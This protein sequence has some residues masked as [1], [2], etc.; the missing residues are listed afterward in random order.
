M[1]HRACLPFLGFT[2]IFKEKKSMRN[3]LIAFVILAC[4]SGVTFAS[5]LF[6]VSVD[7]A[8]DVFYK[9]SFTG[10]Y[11]NEK[12]EIPGSPYKYQG[13]GDTK[14][15]QSS[16]FDNSIEGRVRFM[17]PGTRLGGLLELRTN[18]D[19]LTADIWY[20]ETWL[21]LGPVRILAGNQGQRGQ[22]NQYQNFDDFLSTKID[23]CG[24]LIPTWQKNWYYTAGNNFDAIESFPWGYSDPEENKGFA[25]FASSDTNDLF[26]PAG[27][28]TRLPL[29]ILFDLTIAPVTITASFGGLFSEYTRPFLRPWSVGN[30]E[31]LIDW[32]NAYD[33]VLSRKVNFGVRVETVDIANVI[34]FAATYK[35]SDSLL[36]KPTAKIDDDV[37]EEIIKHHAF[38]LYANITPLNGLGVSVAYSGQLQTWE[39]P[40]YEKTK[41]DPGGMDVSD[42]DKHY[43]SQWK[44]VDFP[45]Y[46]AVDLRFFYTGIENLAITFN[47]NISFASLKGDEAGVNTDEKFVNSWVYGGQLNE[48]LAGIVGKRSEDYLGIYNA[49]GLRYAVTNDM[50]A[51]FQ[52][53]NQ[54]GIFTLN[55]E[56][57][58]LKSETN[59]LGM[60]AGVTYTVAETAYSR[61]S[62]RGGFAL[63]LSSFSYH[64]AF[65]MDVYKAGITDI[66]IPIGVKVEF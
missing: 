43:F 52:I 31:R 23:Y 10:D 40:K 39:N 57:D 13:T 9:R 18:A 24:V 5:E 61:A 15:F 25:K 32:D 58:T 21:R 65:T 3:V 33:P 55:W 60:Y 36:N 4:M 6:T 56:K 17:Y 41:I 22:I 54:H 26:T 28:T 49:L 59:Y 20:W 44:K 62:I 66:G 34:S 8:A 37:I 11:E 50:V 47:N 42:A 12:P 48:N 35:Y 63:K 16:F 14:F 30:K 29:N 45:F 51:D 1:E 38:G 7:M 19:S 2:V 64:D 27:S 53:A 46:N